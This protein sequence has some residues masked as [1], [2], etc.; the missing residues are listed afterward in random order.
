M[1]TVLGLSLAAW[2]VI[3][4]LLRL[5]SGFSAPATRCPPWLW[6]TTQGTCR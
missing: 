3:W 4:A 6:P 5:P 2:L 1:R